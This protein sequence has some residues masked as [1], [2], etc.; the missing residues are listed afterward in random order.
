[1]E[2]YEILE[3]VIRPNYLDLELM[4]LNAEKVPEHYLYYELNMGAIFGVPPAG[5]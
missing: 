3:P 2:D 4:L 1:M 5:S